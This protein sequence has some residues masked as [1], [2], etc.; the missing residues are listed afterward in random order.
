[1]SQ[2]KHLF[3][4]R[5]ESGNHQNPFGSV[6]TP[7]HKTIFKQRFLVNSGETLIPIPT[8]E[9]AYFYAQDRW[10]YLITKS[11]KRYLINYKFI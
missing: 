3:P 11:N 4:E 5:A 7:V 9:I 6:R 2:F 10:T 8:V 1:M